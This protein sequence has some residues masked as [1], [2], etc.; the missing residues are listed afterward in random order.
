MGQGLLLPE[1]KPAIIEFARPSCPVCKTME[2]ILLE[3]K[4]RSRGHWELH[5]AY[6]EPEEYLFKKFGV[7]IVP[8]QVF[9][10]ASGREVYRHEGLMSKEELIKKLQELQFVQE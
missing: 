1:G 5:F 2:K 4:A 6:I 9:L 7:T 3:V 10:D 8:T